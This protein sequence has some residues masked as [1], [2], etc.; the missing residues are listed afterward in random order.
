MAVVTEDEIADVI[1]R[2]NPVLP[3]ELNDVSVTVGQPCG[4]LCEC[5][6]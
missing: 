5:V 1:G 4:E 6:I 3:D 2:Q